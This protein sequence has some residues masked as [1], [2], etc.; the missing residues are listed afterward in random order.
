MLKNCT[1]ILLTLFCSFC[2]LGQTTRI[3]TD[4]RGYW[5]STTA[6]PNAVRPDT[7]HMLLGFMHDGITYSTGVND[8][9]LASQGVS[10]TPGDWRAFPVADILGNYGAGPGGGISC[11]I[12]LANKVD[13]SP[14]TGNVQSV[15]N[16][17]I[18]NAL[19]DGVKGLDLGTGVTNLPSTAVLNF[20]IFGIDPTKIDDNEPDIILTQIADPSASQNDIFSLRDA[21]GNQVG[22]TFTQDMTTLSSFGTYTLDLFNLTPNTPYNA[23]TVY[24][25]FQAH[26]DPVGTVRTRPIRVVAIKLSAFGITA[27]NVAQ[28]GSLRIAP[29]G[30]SDYAFIAYNANS[31][32]LSPNIAPN[33]PLTNTAVCDNGIAHLSIVATAAEGGALSYAWEESTDGGSTWHPVTDGGNY[34]GAATDRLAITDPTDGYRYRVTVTEAGN[35]NPVTSEVFQVTVISSPVAPTGVTIAGGGTVCRGTPIQLT[36]TVTGGSNLFYQWESDPA[37]TNN[38]QPVPDANLS[39]YVPPVDQIGA[40]SYRLRISSGSACI[41]SLTSPAEVITINGIS[42]T[43]SAERCGPGTVNLSAAANAGTINWYTTDVG[44][45][46]I[47]TGSPYAPNLS[48]S[49]IYYVATSTCA[50]ASR[51]P[52]QATI[53]PASVGGT[54]N[55]STTVPSGNNSTTLTLAG[56]TG[57]V[58]KW[59]SSTDGFVSNIVDI[60][61]A[62]NQLTVTNLTQ[63]TSYRVQVQSG[64]CTPEFS[65]MATINMTALA[66]HMGSFKAT[67]D[68]EGI[69]TEWIAYN[70]QSTIQFEIERAG[71]DGN[72]TKVHTVLSNGSGN[73]TKYQWLDAGPVPGRNYYRIKEIYR[74]GSHE[75]STI[76][77]AMFENGQQGITVYPNPVVNKSISLEFRDMNA[78]KYQV[79]YTNNAGQVVY[80]RTIQHLGGYNTY[81]SPLPS[82][83]T[84]GVYRLVITAADGATRTSSTIIIQ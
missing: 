19:I 63:T 16:Y 22:N 57:A 46:T 36:S 80:K 54:L 64:S 44:G 39:T 1:L 65:T 70:Q 33:P 8:G 7:S 50:S 11:Y 59:Q 73:D 60:A 9:I 34:A 76:V 53:S 18:K 43:T 49:A 66:I 79:S 37:G 58:D 4:F 61:N 38:F 24:S 84:P 74:S 56:Y 25:I 42:S 31:I 69:R 47:A 71:A 23:A 51:V 40:V 35:P 14:S 75:Y 67:R 30:I 41:P 45:S 32:S 28:V 2:T 21:A 78:G 26:N 52:V 62:A 17:S 5:S 12:A 82:V 3:I 29:S 68:R 55:G 27:A 13:R 72:F 6:S 15:S 77:S 10:Y 20:R 83:I 81:T 48:G